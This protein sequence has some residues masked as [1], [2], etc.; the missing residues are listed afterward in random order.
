M[1]QTRRGEYVGDVPATSRGLNQDPEDAK[2][3]GQQRTQADA[4]GLVVNYDDERRIQADPTKSCWR[5]GGPGVGR[6]VKADAGKCSG[7]ESGRV[8]GDADVGPTC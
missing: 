8:A 7:P 2:P 5:R 6:D 4:G 1:T 3:K